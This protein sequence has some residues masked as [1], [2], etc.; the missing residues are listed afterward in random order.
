LTPLHFQ[1]HADRSENG[2][3]TDFVDAA[4]RKRPRRPAVPF[5]L[6]QARSDASNQCSFKKA[7][8]MNTAPRISATSRQ[9][10]DG[11]VKAK[12]LELVNDSP[13]SFWSSLNSSI[14]SLSRICNWSAHC[15]VLRRKRVRHR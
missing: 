9:F 15:M 8:Y 5:E 11:F 12:T 7:A 14:Q 4:W 10:F 2:S 6:P 1:L 3:H 13:I